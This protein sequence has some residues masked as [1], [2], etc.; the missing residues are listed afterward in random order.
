VDHLLLHCEIASTCG[1][2][3]VVW[4][5]VSSC[6]LWYLWSE[7]NERSFEDCERIVVELKLFFFKTLYFQTTVL[8][9]N[10]LSFHDFFDLFSL[11]R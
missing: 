3:I 6:F 10:V 9:L 2:S 1:L 4:K 7:R 8:D 5:I 11:S